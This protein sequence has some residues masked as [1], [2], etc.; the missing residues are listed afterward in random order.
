MRKLYRSSSLLPAILIAVLIPRGARSD[1]E[2]G[3]DPA[4]VL[5]SIAEVEASM[6]KAGA[7]FRREASLFGGYPRGWTADRAKGLSESKASPTLIEIQ[8]P[9]T[10]SIGL[11]W[12]EAW[13]Q[14]NDPLYLQAAREVAQ[15]LAWCQL[16]SGGWP[17][18]FDFH[19]EKASRFHLRRDLFAGDKEPGRRWTRSSLDDNKTQSALLF[20]L[21]LSHLEPS[22]DDTDLQDALAFGLDSL[23][24]AQ[25]PNGGWPQMYDGPADPS[26]PADLEASYDENW[27][28]IF[29]KLDY[30]G[31]YTLNDG[32]I[33][34][35]TRLLARAHE[36]TGEERFLDAMRRTGEFLLAAQLPDPHPAW[37][38]QY[39]HAMKPAWARKFEPPA[40]SSLESLWA[41][42][43]L[44]EIWLVTGE[45][46]WLE[47]F[48]RAIA[49]LRSVRLEDGR[50]SRLYELGTNRP[51]YL[52]A[53][54]YEVTYDD[55][56]L[57]THYGFKIDPKLGAGIDKLEEEIGAGREEL[58]RRRR[59]MTQEKSWTKRARG[60]R[61][62]VRE[63]MTSLNGK[64]E[65]LNDDGELDSRLFLK[66]FNALVRYRE[67]A[68]KGGALFQKQ[69][70]DSQPPPASPQPA[71]ESVVPE[72]KEK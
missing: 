24:A 53:D 34:Q 22:R 29:P 62:E 37:A 72:K 44:R 5:P 19:P 47:P 43:T 60:M 68:T 56:N 59:P 27:L 70:K 30:T 50:W 45:E 26:L 55:S 13:E 46:R 14:T 16:A 6:K 39:D 1:E 35:V 7:A 64:G 31:Y 15:A 41:L 71:P 21:E 40:V 54:T 69:W 58:L 25:A 2:K 18:D 61:R 12:I 36:L 9:G 17:S 8:P 57:P 11:A 65:W 66:R 52:V 23:L 4:D 32:N 48:D 33:Y 42:Q 28:R 63:A 67:A 38:Q 49:W 20:L 3:G 51:L 10:P